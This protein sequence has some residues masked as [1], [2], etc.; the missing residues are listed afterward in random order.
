MQ[1]SRIVITALTTIVMSGLSAGSASAAPATQYNSFDEDWG[2][3]DVEMTVDDD[4]VHVEA[5][6]VVSKDG[7]CIK[8]KYKADRRTTWLVPIDAPEI[9]KDSVGDLA[10]TC[11]QAP[12]VAGEHDV[13]LNGD[14]WLHHVSFE[15]CKI[16]SFRSDECRTITMTP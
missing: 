12:S 7:S 14:A 5:S 10:R 3:A 2:S 16:R 9:Q 6:N 1:M 11:D 13:Q 8:L 15:F 4:T